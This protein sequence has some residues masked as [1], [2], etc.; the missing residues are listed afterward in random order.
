MPGVSHGVAL[1]TVGILAAP[2]IDI[3]SKLAA[4]TVTPVQ[5]TAMR[6]I[7]QAALM[8]PFVLFMKR[9]IR[10]DGDGSR[11]KTTLFHALRGLLITISMIAF[12]STLRV[13]EVA[14]AVAIF[15]VEPVILTILG[16]IFLKETVGWRRY[17][18]CAVGFAGA[19]IVVRPSFQ[20]VGP[21]ALLPIVAAFAIALF[22][23][24]TR[25]LA[26]RENPFAMQFHTGIWGFGICAAIMLVAE[27][28][29]WTDFQ[30][31]L[32]DTLHTGYMIGVGVAAAFSGI[33]NVFAYRYAPAST[34]APLQ[35]FEIVSATIFGWLVFDA[36]P[37]PIKW[38]GISII[39]A[40][41]LYIIWRERRV[42]APAIA[43]TS[44]GEIPPT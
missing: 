35:Y 9:T 43:A 13:M 3:F 28:L 24:F 32:P 2:L 38:L 26:Q 44:L 8:A 1:A 18:A 14:D 30:A 33:L 36:F 23:M 40:S 42:K 15:F 19:M 11:L 4:D 6:F 29:G 31:V 5:I 12:V 27:P 16:N 25:M 34:L 17:T 39:I 21:V 7:V 20:E 10:V 37:D 41:G 22:A